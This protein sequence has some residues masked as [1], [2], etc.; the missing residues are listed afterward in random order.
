MAKK[1][2]IFGKIPSADIPAVLHTEQELTDEQ[3]TQARNNIGA[4]MPPLRFTVKKEDGAY[5]RS[6]KTFQELSDAYADGRPLICEYSSSKLPL[7]SYFP[8]TAAGF[9]ISIDGRDIFVTVTCINTVNVY[10]SP[11]TIQIGD[12]IWGGEDGELEVDFTDTING[13]IAA[14]AISTMRFINIHNYGAVGDGETDDTE[15]IQDALYAAE[16]QGLPLYI[17]AGTYLVSKTITTHTRLTAEEKEGLT[18]DELEAAKAD[19]DDRQSKTLNIFGAGMGTKFVTA[20]DFEGDY[21]FHIDVASAQPRMLWV[22]DFAI[23]LVADVSGIYFDEIGM[24][25][26]IENLWINHLYDKD[27]DDTNVRTGIYCR[28]STVTTFRRVK[29]MGNLKRIG[30]G[31]ENIGIAC[32]ATYSTKFID[33]DI[34][35]CKWAIYLSGGS[36]NLVENCRIDENEYGVYQNTTAPTIN[37][38]PETRAYPAD[39]EKFKGTARNLTIR[40]NRFEANN[41]QAIFLAAYSYGEMNYMYNAQVTIA[42]NDFSTLGKHLAKHTSAREVFSK[43]IWLYQCKGVVIENNCF[44][45]QPYDETV[46]DTRLQNLVGERIEDITLRG[47]VATT[48]PI[49]HDEETYTI[50][51]SNP[52][53]SV[54]FVTA[55][56]FIPD[57]EADQCT[58]YSLGDLSLALDSI[59]AMQEQTIALQESLIGGDAE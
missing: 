8:E 37:Y 55:T 28:E 35:F 26:L 49:W 4:G 6:S 47:N 52:V 14:N 59:L 43:A 16:A 31:L 51:K 57:I 40:N 24:A 32:E 23:D 46:A 10:D 17:P 20:E 9:G 44:S 2:Q 7:V 38:M 54:E 27:P 1:L 39:G 15:A 11:H 34:I 12:Q 5:Y 22:H 29:V 25:S 3:K 58:R 41:Q 19:R 33:C 45:G 53:L 21:V 18:E 42:N 56:E 36:N 13:M 30:S 48:K 50:E